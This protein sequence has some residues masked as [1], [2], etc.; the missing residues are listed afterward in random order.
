MKKREL[1][2]SVTKKD[3]KI[4]YF[5]GTGAGGQHRNK[6]QNCVR[7]NHKE[8]GVTV[9]GQSNRE[10]QAN[11]R[12]AFNSLVKHPKFKLWMNMRV[13]EIIEG[14]KIE[15]KVDEQMAPEFLKIEAKDGNI[16]KQIEI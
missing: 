6:H 1:L 13:N 9:T 3:F 11:I 7:I 16:W 2:F 8:S 14:K 5:S 10:R 15:E 12:E 4:D